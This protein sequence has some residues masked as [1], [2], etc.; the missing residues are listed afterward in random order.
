LTVLL[1]P[2]LASVARSAEKRSVPNIVLILADD[3]GYAELGCYGQKKIR[4][5]SLDKMAAEGLRFTQNYCGSPVCAPSRCCLMTGKHGGHAWVRNN[6]EVKPEGQTPLPKSEVTVAE[7]LK[8]QGYTTAAIGKW[9]LGPPGTEGDPLQHGFDHF[10]GYNCQRH[11]HNHYPTYLW[12][13]DKKEKL[14][15]N[16][17]TATGKQHSHDLF[18]REALAFLRAHK[19]K[20]FFLYLPVTIPHVAI[21]VPDDSLAEYKGKWDDPAY[22]GKKGY[23]PHPSPRAGYAAMVTRMDRTV[24]RILDL[25]KELKIEDNTLVLFSSDNGPT[26]GGVGGSDSIFF[27][28]AGVFRGLKGD[29]YEG[30]IRVPFI[31]RWPGKI[32]PGTTD[33]VCYFPDMLPTLLDAAGA[34]N[35][36]PKNV[37]GISFLPTLLGQTDKQKPHEYLVWEFQGYG[38]QQ[39]LRMGDWKAVR[40]DINKGN[41]KIELYN[42][43]D[44]VS[45]KTNVAEKH[46]DVVEKMKK[47]MGEAHAPSKLYPLKGE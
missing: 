23:Q 43:K 31:A 34:A 8:K 7:L 13:D 22:D 28:S 1:S 38:G 21:Q 40:R 12:R 24:G 3:L 32:K 25:L 9:G 42:L 16:D 27:E 26:H 17:G 44:D 33:H 47:L 10:F 41:T 18:E 4:T 5:P 37:D 29:V 6:T 46:A 14:E 20:P 2:A 45:E 15:G 19:D 11:A 39:A 30:G 36:V 35:A